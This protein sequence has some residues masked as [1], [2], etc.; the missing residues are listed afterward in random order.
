MVCFDYAKSKS[1]HVLQG[2]LHLFYQTTVV[3]VLRYKLCAFSLSCI[4]CKLVTNL[5]EKLL[6]SNDIRSDVVKFILL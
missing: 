4:I 3:Q 1:A 2:N 6:K 5:D